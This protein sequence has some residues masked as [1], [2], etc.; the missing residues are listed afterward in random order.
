MATLYDHPPPST[1][2]LMR[3]RRK[4]KNEENKFKIQ[5]IFRPKIKVGFE[6]KSTLFVRK[7]GRP[8]NVRAAFQYLSTVLKRKMKK[9]NSKF[10]KFSG[11]KSK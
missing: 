7:L 2:E 10:K 3:G 11:Q 8:Q 4:E 9:I 1:K 6:L 5:K